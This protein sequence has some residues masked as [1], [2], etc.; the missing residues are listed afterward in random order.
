MDC[1]NSITYMVRPGDTLY[2]IA[3]SYG[4][5]VQNILNY[6]PHINAYNLRIGE[7]LIF[8]TENEVEVDSPVISDE[9][10]YV[11]SLEEFDLSNDMRMTWVQHVMWTRMLII[12]IVNEL[13]DIDAVT[14][15]LLRNPKDLAYLFRPFY[16]DATADKI[17]ELL[18]EHLTIGK[19]L[20]TA[21]KNRNTSMTNDL[22]NRWYN[23]ADRMAKA[24]ASINP[25]YSYEDMRD[26]LYRHLDLTKQEVAAR[27][28]G[29]YSLD[30][31]SFDEV[32]QQALGMADVFTNGLVNQFPDHFM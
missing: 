28:A 14:E 31:Q 1:T 32:E 19:A 12:S 24:F 25:Y 3:M 11:I 17:D 18:T 8:C 26:M 13:K 22:N 23:N 30:I 15:R 5:S 10:D 6:N 29:N 16:G 4:T 7:V 20:I 2:T 9:E 21:T 27:L